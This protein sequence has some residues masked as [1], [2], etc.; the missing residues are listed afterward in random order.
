MP[1]P[2]AAQLRALVATPRL[3]ALCERTPAGVQPLVDNGQLVVLTHADLLPAFEAAYAAL[4]AAKQLTFQPIDDGIGIFAHFPDEV[5]SI[6]VDPG[7]ASDVTFRGADLAALRDVAR[8]TAV[9]RLAANV[10]QYDAH[11]F[12]RIMREHRRFVVPLQPMLAIPPGKIEALHADITDRGV[13]MYEILHHQRPD[14]LHYA[15]VFT[16]DDCAEAFF[17][18]LGDR[19]KTATI[20]GATLFQELRRLEETYGLTSIVL[21]MEG[22][23]P[24]SWLKIGAWRLVLT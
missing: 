9:V 13:V 18:S 4:V 22:P 10:S 1:G 7:T 14:G 8:A 11:A 20:D 17:R 12:R 23:T 24:Q 15:V 16:Y 3:L 5:T 19:T 2:T 21:D 6:R